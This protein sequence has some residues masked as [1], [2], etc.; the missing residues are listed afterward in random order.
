MLTVKLMRVSPGEIWIGKVGASNCLGHQQFHALCAGSQR[1]PG[2]GAIIQSAMRRTASLALLL[3][4]AGIRGAAA[5]EN[6]TPAVAP[7]LLPWVGEETSLEALTRPDR[8]AWPARFTCRPDPRRRRALVIVG[9]SF[10]ELNETLAAADILLEDCR[11]GFRLESVTPEPGK[12]DRIV[13]EG[14]DDA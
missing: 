4:L 2:L 14:D 9:E 13:S 6:A 7:S 5:A 11:G 1:R 3:A 10:R 12:L 8:F